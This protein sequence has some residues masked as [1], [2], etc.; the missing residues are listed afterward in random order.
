M[1]IDVLLARAAARWGDRPAL[2]DGTRSL[3]YA[4]V[5]ARVTQLSA[6][7]RSTGLSTGDRVGILMRNR[8]EAIEALFAAFRAG[9]VAVPIN[10][11]LHATEIGYIIDHAGCTAL[12]YG[13]DLDA[14]VSRADVAVRIGPDEYEAFLAAGGAAPRLVVPDEAPA[15]LFYTSGTTGRP[16]GATLTHRNLLRMVMACLADMTGYQ[17]TDVVLHA[18]PLSHG[19]G[20]YALAAIARGSGNLIPPLA[21]FEARQV[22]EIIERERVS[23]LSFI[24]PTML[25]RL[26]DELDA[27]R[28]D[29]SSM[30]SIVYGGGPAYVP[31]LQR[32]VTRFGP[33]VTQLYGQGESPMTITYLPSEDHL[34]EDAVG[35]VGVPHPDVEVQLLDDRARP[36]PVGASGEVCVRGDV[37]MAGY[38]RDTLATAEA[39]RSGWLHTGDIGRFDDRGYLHLLDRKKDIIISGGSNIYPREV[40]DVLLQHPGVASVAV[41]G[42]PDRA[43]GESVYAAVVRAP[44]TAVDANELIEFCRTRIATYKKP[45]GVL[46]IDTLPVSPVGKVLKSQLRELVVGPMDKP[47]GAVETEASRAVPEGTARRN[48]D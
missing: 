8:P 24:T 17:P 11:R 29:I 28:Y 16:K 15:W 18:A 2:S 22:L 45:K 36:V 4:T 21:S 3:S 20:L 5:D 47:I 44:G 38:W 10:A 19:A 9:L 1:T 34:D 43:W 13:P 41:F 23:V 32:A 12:L 48:D 14:S 33:I 25:L 27:T 31:D 35:S 37:V 30:R 46:F 39:I 26:L 6:G 40:E 7:L 42:I